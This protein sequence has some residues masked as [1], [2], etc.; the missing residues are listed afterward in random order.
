MNQ[1]VVLR[2]LSQRARVLQTL[3]PEVKKHS[4]K[5]WEKAIPET[6]DGQAYF[7]A[8][9]LNRAYM[10][11]LKKELKNVNIAIRAIKQGAKK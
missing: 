3:I 4:A 11:K 5:M 2:V 7:E 6:E 9:S 10:L 8:F 1:N